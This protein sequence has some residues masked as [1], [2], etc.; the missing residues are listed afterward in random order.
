MRVRTLSL[1]F[2]LLSRLA[3]AEPDGGLNPMP[4]HRAADPQAAEV[5]EQNLLESERSWP[6]H[7]ELVQPLERAGS[8][9]LPSGTSGVL[10]RVQKGGVARIDF[11]RDG[12]LDVPVAATDIV[13]RANQIR[14]GEREKSAPHFVYAM[15]TRLLDS[16]APQLQ[17]LE[18]ASVST[19][20]R[21][22]CVFADPRAP[23]FAKLARVLAPLRDQPG[24][25]T[26]LFPQ[27]RIPDPEVRETLRALGW[28]VPFVYDH[29]SEAY[30]A[31]LLDDGVEP[32]AVLLQTAEGRVLHQ[33]GWTGD[34]DAI[35][36]FITASPR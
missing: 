29:L 28:T 16:A 25:L 1:L 20:A 4:E 7:V 15:G 24:T 23:D 18:L 3:L 30:T 36:G 12:R 19:Y 14:L 34:V 13:A 26:I 33:S 35:L 32:P 27:G 5:T 8:G 6:Y 17:P 22:L 11:G 10:I 9:A 31:S 21:F 2:A